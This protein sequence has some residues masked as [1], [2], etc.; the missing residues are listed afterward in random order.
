MEIPLNELN[1]DENMLSEEIIERRNSNYDSAPTI[2]PINSP[3]E[4]NNQNLKFLA[5]EINNHPSEYNNQNIIQNNNK[6]QIAYKHKNSSKN[7]T[8]SNRNNSN[9]SQETHKQY[10]KTLYNSREE[11]RKLRRYRFT[12]LTERKE[13]EKLSSKILGIYIPIIFLV[14]VTILEFILQ[15]SIYKSFIPF[16]IVF[17]LFIINIIWIIIFFILQINPCCIF[18]LLLL[19]LLNLSLYI[20]FIVMYFDDNKKKYE[21]LIIS[22]AFIK[23]LLFLYVNCAICIFGNSAKLKDKSKNKDK[24]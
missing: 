11:Y 24:F 9:N 19:I 23:L 6:D 4:N 18:F 15:L 16:F 13:C 12:L 3:I 5:I 20:V 8:K 22:L 14:L 2:E 17:F 10:V 7:K 1:Q 21:S